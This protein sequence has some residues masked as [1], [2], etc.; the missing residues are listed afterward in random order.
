MLA[1]LSADEAKPD[2]REEWCV[3]LVLG[4]EFGPSR[5]LIVV[6]VVLLGSAVTRSCSL[7]FFL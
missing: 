2:S 1:Q 6:R 5:S 4:F 3:F 7:L